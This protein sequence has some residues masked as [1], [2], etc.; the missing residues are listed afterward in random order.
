VRIN[1][2]KKI[3]SSFHAHTKFRRGQVPCVSGQGA[4]AFKVYANP[5]EVAS[6]PVPDLSGG[7]GLWA[8]LSASREQISEGGILR[9][10]Q[11]SQI[12]WAAAGFTFGRQRT[13]ISA[14]GISTIETYLVA[15]NV[16]DMFPGIYHYNPRDHTLE[17][18]Q[19]G[20]PSE[21]LGNAL[22]PNR[23]IEANP[24]AVAFTGLPERLEIGA[25]SRAYRYVYQEAGAAA[26]AA[27][28]AAGALD[29]VATFE[30]AFYDDDLARLL[31]ID[32]V[33]EVP[34]CLV[35]LGT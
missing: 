5:L 16:E 31:Q 23:E 32:G 17:Y 25:K 28:L 8:A 21:P 7:K 18:V 19:G 24:A 33:I 6:L 20:D 22:L 13:H 4:A 35:L 1:R 14:T 9:Q 27:A 30:V 34:L 15:N 3:G 10:A 29:L 2:G 11:A 12:L 26:Q